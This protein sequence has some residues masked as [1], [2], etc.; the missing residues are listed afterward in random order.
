MAAWDSVEIPDLQGIIR[1]LSPESAFLAIS[2]SDKPLKSQWLFQQIPCAR[3]R[4]VFQQNRDVKSWNSK[5]PFLTHLS[6]GVA[7]AIC[8]RR[9]F[10]GEDENDGGSLPIPRALRRGLLAGTP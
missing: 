2:A 1:E 7:V 5:R 9:Q 4:E 10:A 6:G 8:S 3:I